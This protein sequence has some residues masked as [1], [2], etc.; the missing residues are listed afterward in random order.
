MPKY[1]T[2]HDRDSR[3]L[4]TVSELRASQKEG[5]EDEGMNETDCTE[6]NAV[7]GHQADI[8]EFTDGPQRAKLYCGGMMDNQEAEIS[9]LDRT[10]RGSWPDAEEI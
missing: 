1:E 10:E 7:Q 6:L 9:R 4:P 5:M 8:K 2:I 3:I